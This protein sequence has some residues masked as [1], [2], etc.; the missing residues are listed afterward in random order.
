VYDYDAGSCNTVADMETYL[1][2]ISTGNLEVDPLFE[3]QTGGDWNLSNG[4]SLKFAGLD[5]SASLTIDRDGLP[6]TDPWS[7]GAYEK[8]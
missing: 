8:D 3:D 7:I 5:L 2:G 6:R 4:S 1:T